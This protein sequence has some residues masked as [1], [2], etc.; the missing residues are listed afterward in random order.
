MLIKPGIVRVLIA[1]S[2]VQ[3]HQA[4]E[5]IAP[6]QAIEAMTTRGV[7]NALSNAQLAI[8]QID[9]LI[10]EEIARETLIDVLNRSHIPWTTPDSFLGDPK[11]W[12]A[13]AL[14]ARKLPQLPPATA[15]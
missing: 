9:T 12:R 10:E 5:A 1:T 2:Q 14:A 13:H 4:L 6:Y 11:T 3:V 8:V 15:A 7:Y